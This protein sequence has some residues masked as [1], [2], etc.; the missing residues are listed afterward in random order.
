MKKHCS[1]L[2]FIWILPCKGQE[3]V[4]SKPSTNCN[5]QTWTELTDSFGRLN[6]VQR[7]VEL[8][9]GIK[10]ITNA[11]DGSCVANGF[12]SAEGDGHHRISFI[13]RL[14]HALADTSCCILLITGGNDWNYGVPIGNL[15]DTSTDTYCG[16]LNFIARQIKRFNKKAIWVTMIQRNTARHGGK[17]SGAV[18]Y[19]DQKKYADAMMLIGKNNAIQ[20]ID[21]FDSSGITYSNS[22]TFMRDGAH[23]DTYAGLLVYAD[24]V[25]EQLLKSLGK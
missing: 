21:A 16:A 9:L 2:L 7:T 15:T 24:F 8:R 1:L 18:N 22:T 17:V 14:P 12:D 23:P 10:V 3:A 25:A 19:D 11:V 5:T 4:P 13:E 20:V 6:V